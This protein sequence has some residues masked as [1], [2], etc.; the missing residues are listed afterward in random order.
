MFSPTAYENAR[1]D[2][3]AVLEI[4]ETGVPGSGAAS[5]A[6]A[7]RRFVPLKR[8]ELRGEIV[9][10]LA[11]LR[12][13]HCFG[14]TREQCDRVLEA[15]YR[16]PLPGDAAVSGVRVRFG[17]VEIRAELRERREAE[18]SYE[19]ARQ[20]GRQAALLTRESPDVFTLQVAGIAPDQDVVVETTYVQLAHAQ[21]IGWTLRAPLTT[22]P[23]YVRSD[24]LASRH[25]QGQPLF[26]LRDPGHRVA[27]DLE[28][29]GAAAVE[30]PTHALSTSGE[31]DRVRVRLSDGEVLPDRDLVLSWRPR[32]ETGRP[33]L[34]AWLHDDAAAGYTYFL[35]LVAPPLA[36]RSDRVARESIVLVDHSGSMEGPKWEAADWAVGQFLAGLGT[37]DR[38][39]LGLFHNTTRWLARAPL[40]ASPD[41]IRQANR[42]LEQHRDSGGTE[43]GVAL[44]QALGLERGPAGPG[45]YS[46]HVLVIT[47]AEV[48]D[49]G[50]ILR[51]ADEEF[52]RADRR[53]ISV[54]CIDAAPNAFLATELATRGGGVARFLTSAPDA[55]DVTTALDEVLLD[56]AQPVLAGLQLEIDRG[57]VEAAGRQVRERDG[58]AAVD[59]GDLP[60]GRTLWVAGR[61][62][63]DGGALTLRLATEHEFEVARIQLS[64]VASD[65]PTSASRTDP[66]RTGG[67]SD[68]AVSVGADVAGRDGAGHHTAAATALKALFGARRVAGLEYLMH[69]GYAGAD[70]GAALRRLGY[71]EHTAA[72]VVDG[73]AGTPPKVYAENTRRD[74][75]AA[76]RDL[77]V[78]EALDYGLASAETAFVAARTE[79]GRPVEGTV[80][81]ANALPSGWSDAFL[82]RS[83]SGGHQVMLATAAAPMPAAAV[84]REASIPDLFANRG[85][86]SF[87]RKLSRSTSAARSTPAA[88]AAESVTE[89]PPVR[90]SAALFAGV[91]SFDG[92]EAML[93]DSRDET[94]AQKLPEMVTLS[95]L[96][97]RFTGDAPALEAID[98]GLSL[99]LY[100]DDLVA[101]RARV[102][103][104]DLVRRGG[105]RPLNVR[106]LADQ[107]VRLVLADAGG[108]WAGTAPSLEIVVEWTP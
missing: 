51:L 58:T 33:T 92:R 35:A 101:P 73:Q 21:G 60:A 9:G 20:E 38:F 82:A 81:V 72:R 3:V 108:A 70:L 84:L 6:H 25:A 91:P 59:L 42:F 46:R 29:A 105:E 78:R 17:D 24:E 93:F 99:F 74:A 55:G 83:I 13:T 14:Y 62:P 34:A 44:E 56:W 28:F 89:S 80:P 50:R 57:R 43:L 76:L 90:P 96:R 98:P 79:R 53:R 94:E 23:R 106:R 107:V 22:A 61:V 85:P 19:A 26:L 10:P 64:S 103:V 15:V 8:T 30:S 77:L 75:V 32:Q 66:E 7:V 36:P 18:T 49:A 37:G 69:A 4:V 100:V 88:S 12:L 27:L 87:L 63:R 16:F 71:D 67:P 11:A 104:A 31:H 45:D 1:P 65:E 2:G 86:R 52:A 39:D 47:D 68:A 5:E 95:R 48:S 54:L 41:T 97:L 102:S 40:D